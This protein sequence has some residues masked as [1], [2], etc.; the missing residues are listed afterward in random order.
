MS[1]YYAKTFHP[2]TGKIE[3]AEWLD[4]HYGNHMY[5]VRFPDGN[6]YHA[7][8]CEQ[9]GQKAATHIEKL[10]KQLSVSDTPRIGDKNAKN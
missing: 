9:L 5:G 4:D 10:E 8:E 6:V 1:C 2:I 3:T 7:H